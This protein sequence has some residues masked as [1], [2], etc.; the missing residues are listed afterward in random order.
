MATP[1]LRPLPPGP[2]AEDLL[3]VV[4]GLVEARERACR[5][6][7][8]APVLPGSRCEACLEAPAS[9]LV[10]A[11]WGGDQG[12]CAHCRGNTP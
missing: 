2:I 7:A 6:A 1:A 12:V 11:P 8:A 10:P 4:R 5:A 9:A 3:A